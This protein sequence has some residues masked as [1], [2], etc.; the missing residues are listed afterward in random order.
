VERLETRLEGP[1]LLRPVVHGDAR[2]WFQETYR[3][4]VLRE[5]GI[6]D[7]FVQDNHSRS[8]RGVVRGLHLQVGAGQAKLV[9]CAR[10]TVFDVVV[11][12]RP[13]SPAFGRWEGFELDDEQGRQ[14]YCPIG[15]AHGFCVMSE[16]ADVVYKC[17][18][19]YDRDAER[20]IAWDD[21]EIGIEWP[22]GLDLVASDRDAAAPTLRELQPELRFDRRA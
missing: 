17:S 3:R 9:R 14:V 20:S 2:G 22:T 19:Y 10:G 1:V 15:F 4:E 13:D 12:V 11:D 16:T 18:S 6:A 8:R 7:E 5:L 21:P